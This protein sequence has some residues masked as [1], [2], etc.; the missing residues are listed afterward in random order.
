[1]DQFQS[2]TD[3]T[4]PVT[5]YLLLYWDIHMHVYKTLFA[6]DRFCSSTVVVYA[7]GQP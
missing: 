3:T 6:W 1:M 7:V 2:V 5:E 4:T